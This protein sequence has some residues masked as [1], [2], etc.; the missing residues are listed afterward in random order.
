[1]AAW[2]DI[3]KDYQYD[4]EATKASELYAEKTAVMTYSDLCKIE[5]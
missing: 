1:M 2:N 3:S 4:S 5:E